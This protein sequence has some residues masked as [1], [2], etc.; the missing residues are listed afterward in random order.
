MEG[1]PSLAL[2]PDASKL[3]VLFLVRVIPGKF[4]RGGGGV[5]SLEQAWR[6]KMGC[7]IQGPSKSTARKRD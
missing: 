4:T 3:T 5:R 1:P 2:D 7:E 6:E